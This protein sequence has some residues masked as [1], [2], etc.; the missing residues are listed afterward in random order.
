M[1]SLLGPIDLS[2]MVRRSL[3]DFEALREGRQAKEWDSAEVN[4]DLKRRP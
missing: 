3:D 2:G 4:E 1:P